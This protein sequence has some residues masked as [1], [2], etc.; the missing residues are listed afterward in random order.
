MYIYNVNLAAFVQCTT[1]LTLRISPGSTPSFSVTL[2]FLSPLEGAPKP[3]H[4]RM[5]ETKQLRAEWSL[6]AFYTFLCK[7]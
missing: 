7:M 1:C 3:A 5:M 2:V 4:S 6:A